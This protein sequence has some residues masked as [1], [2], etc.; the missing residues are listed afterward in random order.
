MMCALNFLIS[1]FLFVKTDRE[2]R[3]FLISHVSLFYSRIFY[4]RICWKVELHCRQSGSRSFFIS[5]TKRTYWPFGN[6]L[7]HQDVRRRKQNIIV[8]GREKKKLFERRRSDLSAR[9]RRKTWEVFSGNERARTRKW[10]RSGAQ[11]ECWCTGVCASLR[12]GSLPA[13]RIAKV[14]GEG[15]AIGAA[16]G[17][18]TEPSEHQPWIEQRG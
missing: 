17:T 16:A 14:G 11:V 6:M 10:H 7:G 5:R 13:R 1:F 18:S 15:V 2:K 8:L 12:K 9:V 3:Y 4:Q